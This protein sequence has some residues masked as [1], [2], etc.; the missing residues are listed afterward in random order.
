[1]VQ[2]IEIAPKPETLNS[3]PLIA[4]GDQRLHG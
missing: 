1:M 3:E 2:A 4:D